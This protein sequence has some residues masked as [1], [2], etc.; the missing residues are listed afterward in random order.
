MHPRLQAVMSSQALY[1]RVSRRTVGNRGLPIAP[2]I[3]RLLSVKM[4][5]TCVS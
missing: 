1:L 4:G 2:F 5:S 3:E